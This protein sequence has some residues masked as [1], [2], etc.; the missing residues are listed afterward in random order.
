MLIHSE[1]FPKVNADKSKPSFI[2]RI[3]TFTQLLA[4]LLLSC[5]I[6]A[7]A[8]F[9]S[10]FA[11]SLLG[12]IFTA[13]ETIKYIKDLFQKE[14]RFSSLF[15]LLSMGTFAYSA[16]L[17]GL[18]LCTAI[19]SSP[20]GV[21]I[22]TGIFVGWT[23]GITAI[24]TR[25]APKIFSYYFNKSDANNLLEENEESINC[26]GRS[27]NTLSPLRKIGSKILSPGLLLSPTPESSLPSENHIG[28]TMRPRF[29]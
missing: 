3:K 9:I 16:W 8:L 26:V 1:T 4:L 15:S 11:S 18:M 7:L 13:Q 12:A 28:D 25:Y 20:V 21:I 6:L 5:I 23:L 10:L 14:K 24:I 29:R 22:G 27:F 19:F 2:R 17:L